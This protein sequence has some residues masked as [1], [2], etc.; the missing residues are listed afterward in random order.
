MGKDELWVRSYAV[1]KV[2]Q[3]CSCWER[4]DVKYSAGSLLENVK[5]ALFIVLKSI[6]PDNLL[7]NCRTAEHRTGELK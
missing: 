2:L 4:F 5:E 6:I 3:F 1:K 7:I